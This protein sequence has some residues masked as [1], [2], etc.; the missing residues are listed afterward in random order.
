MV[1]QHRYGGNPDSEHLLRYLGMRLLNQMVE[2][3]RDVIKFLRVEARCKGKELGL[4]HQMDVETE[5]GNGRCVYSAAP[6]S[7]IP[8]WLYHCNNSMLP[9]LSNLMIRVLTT[10]VL[11]EAHHSS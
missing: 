11:I 5:N 10:I 8:A 7:I 3:L 1:K 4:V 9:Y 2:L 6:N